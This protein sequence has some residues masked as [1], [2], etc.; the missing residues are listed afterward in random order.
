MASIYKDTYKGFRFYT[1]NAQSHAVGKDE[2]DAYRMIV[3]EEFLNQCIFPFEDALSN[4][5]E[6]ALYK[7]TK[8]LMTGLFKDS[9][10]KHEKGGQLY[11]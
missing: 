4:T 1:R 2:L 6:N 7:M 8:M 5:L 3:S 11:G 10:T 9:K